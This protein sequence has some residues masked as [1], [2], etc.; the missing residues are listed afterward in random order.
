MKYRIFIVEDHPI[1]RE[2]YASLIGRE[3]G[4]EICG[5]AATGH[6]ALERIPQASPDLVLIDISIPGINGI[7]LIKRLQHQAP[8]LPLLVV[9]AHD[10]T[11]YAERVFRAGAKGYVMK[12][13][14]AS[15]VVRAIN[16]VLAGELFASERIR[17]KFFHRYLGG[18]ASA[19]GTPLEELSD[20]ELEVF[21][22]LGRGY[23]TREIA[24]AM[25]ISPKTVE[26]YR[27]NI[28]NKLGVESSAELTRRAVLW[29][30]SISG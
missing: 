12:H 9:S 2:G 23:S 22:Y 1:M 24:E 3:A 15:I 20:R 7:E 4:M 18:T 10:E 17:N 14:A 8:D 28:K 27:A 21:Q 13:E 11:L 6:E 16:E 30:E 5:E 25:L 19:E 29:V 26:T